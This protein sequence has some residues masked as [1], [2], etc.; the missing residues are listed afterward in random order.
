MK[1][2]EAKSQETGN[3][4]RVAVQAPSLNLPPGLEPAHAA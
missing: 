3:E 2:T 4:V 1:K